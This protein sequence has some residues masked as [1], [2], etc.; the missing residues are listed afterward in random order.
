MQTD[1]A[2]LLEA[3]PK[4]RPQRDEVDVVIADEAS[5]IDIALA[6]A[7]LVALP[8]EAQLILVGDIDQLP[9]VGPGSVLADVIAS[10]AATVVELREIFRQAAQ[11]QIVVAAHRINRGE[12][13]ELAPPSGDDPTR[14]DFYF[15]G[16]DDPLAA[17][18]P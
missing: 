14:T 6:R 17:A 2:G 13:P 5:M 1:A 12:M 8:P 4:E 15:V 3:V 18:A 11:S 9:S 7:L 16:R 10:E